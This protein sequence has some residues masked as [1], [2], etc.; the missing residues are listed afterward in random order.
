MPE[1]RLYSGIVV[2]TRPVVDIADAP[3]DMINELLASMEMVEP[4]GGL[5]SLCLVFDN[6]A[7]HAGVGLDY[8]FEFTET[9]VFELGTAI[10][11]LA[12]DAADPQEIFRGRISAVEF[13]QADGGQPQLKV[14]AEDA[15]MPWRMV[16]RNKTYPAGPLRDIFD[17][18]AESYELSPVITALDQEVDAQQQL[19]ETDLAFLRRLLT[20]YDAD[21]QVVG[22]ELHISP[23]DQ[24]DRG[25]VTL[26]LG[27]QLR[28]IRVCADLAHQRESV[29]LHGF[30]I[31]SGTA[32]E[33]TSEEGA[34]GPGAGRTGPEVVAEAFPGS[35][36]RMA[37]TAF[38][39][40]SE[41]QDL[42]NAMQTRR[43]RRFVIADG[44][45]TGN[46][47]IRVGTKLVL[48]GIGPRFSNTYYTTRSAHCFDRVS[49][50][51]TQFSAEC[52][53]WGIV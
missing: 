29:A 2:D 52:A 5:T 18:L 24:V 41:A 30:D 27:S 23:R 48:E 19:N 25:E 40:R 51:T 10:R 22:E 17:A 6:T 46:S 13:C 8:A 7:D 28:S 47:A 12:G 36:N 1:D 9:N 39:N 38:E 53:F 37:Q 34:L 26:R 44:C 20:R 42:A 33:V 11:V 4:E 43:M 50:Y 14:M 31:V 49:G 15:L 45:A 3:N 16:R 32:E 21:A 35:I